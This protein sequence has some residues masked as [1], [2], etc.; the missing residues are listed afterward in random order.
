MK[1]QGVFKIF[2]SVPH[3]SI[4]VVPGSNTDFARNVS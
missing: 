1:M 4:I 3:S 2:I